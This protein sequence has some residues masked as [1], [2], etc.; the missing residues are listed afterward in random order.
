VLT[1][2]TADR[3]TGPW[4]RIAE[5]E[6]GIGHVGA[7]EPADQIGH[8]ELHDTATTY[9][10][11]ELSRRIVNVDASG[12]FRRGRWWHPAGAHSDIWYPESAH[13]LLS[14]ASLAR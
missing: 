9:R 8:V 13:L 4:H 1:W 11:D 14:L 12:R 2:S 10:R 3:A 5:G 6:A 7:R